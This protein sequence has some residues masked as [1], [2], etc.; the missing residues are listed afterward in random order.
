MRPRP[1]Y[2]SYI[3]RIAA[4]LLALALVPAVHAEGRAECSIVKSAIL[5]RPVRYCA[6]LPASFDQDK[7]R[8]YPVLYYLH[9]L[10]DNEQSLLNMGRPGHRVRI[11]LG[12]R[13]L[14]LR[15]RTETTRQDRRCLRSQPST[16]S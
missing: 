11:A 8:Q 7:A 2:S 9:G 12:M 6:Y 10:G 5:A 4:C 1:T 13:R 16:E 15:H 14:R 3:L